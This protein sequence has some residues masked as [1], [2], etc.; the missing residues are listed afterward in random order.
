MKKEYIE[1]FIK[2]AALAGIDKETAA[3]LLSK[4]AHPGMPGADPS[5]GLQAGSQA[6]DPSGAVP[7]NMASGGVP[8]ELEQIINSLPPEVLAQL[9]QE[10]EA[11]LGGGQGAGQ[12]DGQGGPPPPHH[13]HPMH[14]QP[15]GPPPW[16]PQ[17]MP[18]GPPPGMPQKMGSAQPIVVA[19]TASYIEG[20]IGRALDLGFD[21]ESAK[22]IYKQAL[23]IMESN[24]IKVPVKTSDVEKQS[25][26]FEGF[27]EKAASYGLNQSQAVDLYKRTFGN[28]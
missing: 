22:N 19:K 23:Y 25:S 5:G 24:P 11:E 9:V 27:I 1:G 20:F 13:G 6:P 12:Q 15:Q 7:P 21:N 3:Q 18:Q 2:R 17:G 4:V 8:P 10:I 26:H 14:Q 28:K 16:P